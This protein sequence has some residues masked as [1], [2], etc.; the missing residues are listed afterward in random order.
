MRTVH[1]RDNKGQPHLG[2][3]RS[4][5]CCADSRQRHNR[6]SRI[7]DTVVG[8]MAEWCN[9]PLEPVYPVVFIDA[10]LVKIRDGQVANRP[11]YVAIGSPR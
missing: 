9:R 2:R 1:D 4:V 3:D 6:A 10:I 5:G 11:I 7:T 8:E